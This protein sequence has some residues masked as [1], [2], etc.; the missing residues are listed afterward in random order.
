MTGVACLRWEMHRISILGK[1]IAM[2][3]NTVGLHF[4]EGR[5]RKRT[6]F[7]SKFSAWGGEKILSM[8]RVRG[9]KIYSLYTFGDASG[10]RGAAI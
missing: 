5:G 3:A 4:G 1:I 9:S 10:N 6:P 7:L 2:Q 8:I